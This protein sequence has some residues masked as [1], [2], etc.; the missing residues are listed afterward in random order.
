MGV[1][2]NIK[3][4]EARDLA[5]RLSRATGEGLTE[6]VTAALRERLE[7]L[8]RPSREATRQK[9]LSIGADIAQRYPDLPASAEIDGL[10][11]DEDGLPA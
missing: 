2:L 1:Q 5:E 11:Y 9:W 7:R 10:L 6:A 8:E 4:A 3:S